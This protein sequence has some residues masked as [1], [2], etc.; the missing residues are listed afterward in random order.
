M[1]TIW[2]KAVFHLPDDERPRSLDSAEGKTFDL[3][4]TLSENAEKEV[5]AF[6]SARTRLNID[7]C[8]LNK[9]SLLKQRQ[10]E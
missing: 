4:E 5:L 8:L 7:L 10:V 2:S 6:E 1:Y 3:E 9:A